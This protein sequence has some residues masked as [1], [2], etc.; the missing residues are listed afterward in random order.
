[1]QILLKPS[2]SAQGNAGFSF[3]KFKTKKFNQTV[4]IWPKGNLKDIDNKVPILPKG[5]LNKIFI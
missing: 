2:L 1:M 4:Q 5:N 3:R